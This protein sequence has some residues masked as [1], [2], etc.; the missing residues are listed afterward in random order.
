METSILLGTDVDKLGNTVEVYQSKKLGWSPAYVFFLKQYVELIENGH[1]FPHTTWDDDRCSIVYAKIQGQIVGIIA[2]DPAH[3]E[4]KESLWITLSAVDTVCRQQ[5][6][7]KILHN[8]LEKIAL[9]LEKLMIA[10][11]VH[12]NNI[13]RLASAKSV[14]MKPVYYIIGKKISTL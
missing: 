11:Q 8:Y 12:I 2:Y 14:G 10:S 9:E 3:P 13:P 1:G 6:I 5:G 7:Y 4:Y